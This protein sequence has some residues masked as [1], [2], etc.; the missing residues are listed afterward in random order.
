MKHL[1]I[2]VMSLSANGLGGGWGII[3]AVPTAPPFASGLIA[4][5]IVRMGKTLETLAF[6]DVQNGSNVSLLESS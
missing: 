4:D 6:R 3:V 1:E 2:T 5:I